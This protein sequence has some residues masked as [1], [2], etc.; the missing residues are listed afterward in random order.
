MDLLGGLRATGRLARRSLRPA[1][2]YG[3]GSTAVYRHIGAHRPD[4]CPLAVPPLLRRPHERC[5]GDFPGAADHGGHHVVPQAPGGGYGA[6]P[7][8]P[9]PV[10]FAVCATDGCA[11]DPIRL[12]L[13]VL[14][15]WHCGR[16]T[17]AAAHP[18]LPQRAGR[19]RAAPPRGRTETTHPESAAWRQCPAADRSMSP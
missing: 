2:H 15:T 3:C 17:A 9:G 12:A 13:G 16:A 1:P 4:H 11:A 5:P 7:V 18:F 6:A 8:C 10:E 14:G 19:D